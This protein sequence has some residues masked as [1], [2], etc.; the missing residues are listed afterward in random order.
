MPENPP[1]VDFSSLDS[2]IESFRKLKRFIQ[3]FG[4]LSLEGAEEEIDNPVAKKAF[5]LLVDGWDPLVMRAILDRSMQSYFETERRKLEMVI[6]GFGCLAT[7]EHLMGLE[8]QLS[9]Y[10]Y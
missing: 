4:I 7:K 2:I 9:S 8:E 1:S 5:Q 10:L 6:E 3:E